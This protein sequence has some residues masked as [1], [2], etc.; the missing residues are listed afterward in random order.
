MNVQDLRTGVYLNNLRNFIRENINRPINKILE[1]FQGE[2]K[3]GLS[4]QISSREYVEL[5]RN[6]YRNIISDQFSKILGVLSLGIGNIKNYF[7][8]LINYISRISV[9]ELTKI[10]N[11]IVEINRFLDGFVENIIRIIVTKISEILDPSIEII[12]QKL[13]QYRRTLDPNVDQSLIDL[14]DITYNQIKKSIEIESFNLKQKSNILKEEIK[15]K[16]IELN[17]I[18]ENKMLPVPAFVPITALQLVTAPIT[19]LPPITAPTL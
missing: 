14:L 16:I 7:I 3:G 11:N 13:D 10:E 17:R 12:K 19:A 8:Q 4:I 9:D 15:V 2:L 18:I 1:R 5:V 6:L